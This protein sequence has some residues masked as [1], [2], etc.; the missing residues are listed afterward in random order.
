MLSSLGRMLVVLCV[1]GGITAAD[2]FE[3]TVRPFLNSWCVS[4]HGPE[5]QSGDRRFDRVAVS[6]QDSNDLAQ[7]QDIVDQLNLGEMPPPD[8][9]QPSAEQRKIVVQWLQ[10]RIS[11][12]HQ[13]RSGARDRAALRRLNSR[14][15]RNTVRDLLRINTTLFDPTE[16]FP[17]DQTV[18]HLDNVGDTLVTSG[19]LL[20]QYLRAADLAVTKAVTPLSRPTAK[21]WTFTDN[22]RQQP[23]I[24]QVHRKT[25][26]YRHIT[27]YDVVGADKHEGAYAAIHDFASGVPHDGWYEIQ[28]RAV[29]VN[30]QHPYDV[31]FVGTDPQVPLRLGIRPGLAQA[32]PLHKPQPIEPLL[33]D[34]ALDDEDA[35]YTVKV[36]L[37]AGFTPRF[38]FRNGLMDVRNMWGR[39]VKKYR[40]Q[41]PK[42]KRPGIVEHRFNAIKY[43]KLPQIHVDDIRIRGPLLEEWPT[44]SQLA[45]FGP[46]AAMILESRQMS[47]QQME[48][49]LQRFLPRAYRRPVTVAERQRVLQVI[50]D[51]RRQGRSDI[52]AWCDGIR[53]VLCSPGFLY[54]EQPTEDGPSPALVASRL[55]YFLW[56]SMPDDELLRTAGVI[57]S[58]GAAGVWTKQRVEQEVDR[59]LDDPKAD[60][61]LN[62]FLGSWLTLRDFGSQPPDRDQ[63]AKY[64]HHDLG[65]AMLQETRL[66]ADSLLKDDLSVLQFLNADYTF[67]NRRLAEHYGL[68]KPAG[69]GFHRV[70]LS[71]DR[72]GGLLGQASV[73][74][75]SANGIDTSPVV[76]GVW[77]LENLLG[78][79]PSPPPPDIEPLDPDIR[80][81]KTIRDQLKKHRTS[82]SCNE[83]HRRIDP[84]GFALENFDAV[85][86][87]RDNYDRRQAIDASGELPNGGQFQDVRSFKRLLLN[88]KTLFVRALT[89]KLLSYAAGRRMLVTDR[90]RIDE[91][92]A[93]LADRG[94]G[95]RTLVKLA[96]TSEAVL[97]QPLET[98]GG[99]P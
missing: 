35:Q 17:R 24:D 89:S 34:I 57:E 48:D 26:E 45:V 75:V 56:S 68:P 55:S 21:T 31:D 76:R 84:L 58:A 37:D 82:D 51:R 79:P 72:R 19:Y 38:T 33:A 60:A 99:S 97:E 62:G 18:E 95:F 22:F 3:S 12:F 94:H 64:Y 91:L 10:K 28:F 30:R 83:C 81:A 70:A 5:D 59:M 77:L 14:E 43:G 46:Q 74:T 40:D 67:V 50:D 93:E 78:T 49:Q 23:E 88:Q 32:G 87:W 71:D 85:G 47:R 61:F 90:P 8:E 2:D 25:T 1:C 16:S 13:S 65:T 4:C 42:P 63:F 44:A 98:E 39:L 69:G 86:R 6:L 27:L 52:D 96:A 29:G 20:Q 92:T 80:G 53:M 11:D 66:F 36:W 7:W 54:L 9:R 73:L 41:F 15:Y